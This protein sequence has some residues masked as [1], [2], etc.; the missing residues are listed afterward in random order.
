MVQVFLGVGVL[1]MW[2]VFFSVVEFS[3]MEMACSMVMCWVD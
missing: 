1:C 3:M 2:N